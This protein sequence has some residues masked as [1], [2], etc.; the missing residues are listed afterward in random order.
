MNYKNNTENRRKYT[1]RIWS[2]P[3]K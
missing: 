3:R 2:K 1:N